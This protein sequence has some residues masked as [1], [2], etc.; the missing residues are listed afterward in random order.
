MRADISLSAVDQNILE[1]NAN[2]G[3]IGDCRISKIVKSLFYL[4]FT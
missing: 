2:W 4:Y 3:I 1:Q